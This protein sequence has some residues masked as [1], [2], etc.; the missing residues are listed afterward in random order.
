MGQCHSGRGLLERQVPFQRYKIKNIQHNVSRRPRQLSQA[1]VG[2][3]RHGRIRTRQHLQLT[4]AVV[5]HNVSCFAGPRHAPVD[6]YG[7]VIR[8]Y[9]KTLKARKAYAPSFRYQ[10]GEVPAGATVVFHLAD[11][12]QTKIH[13]L[14]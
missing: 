3:Q 4:K 14:K 11:Q 13:I 1:A 9:R 12:R 8:A 2:I 5:K 10:R 6:L 7:Q